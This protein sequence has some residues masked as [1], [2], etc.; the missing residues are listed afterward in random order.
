MHELLFFAVNKNYNVSCIF[1]SLIKVRL[2]NPSSKP[3]TYHAMIAGRDARDFT[4]PRGNTVAIAPK[5]K[6]DL[7]VEFTSRFLR[8]AE[9]VLVLVGRRAGSACGTTLVFNLRTSI[10]NITPSVSQITVRNFFTSACPNFSLICLNS[11][12]I[13]KCFCMVYVGTY[14]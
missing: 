8:P 2:T 9:G 3:L 12:Y 13:L 1:C 10:D 14:E 4:L 5:G 7:A 6:H 11:V